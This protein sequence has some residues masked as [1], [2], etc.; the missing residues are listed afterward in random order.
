VQSDLRLVAE[1]QPAVVQ[2]GEAVVLRAV[3]TGPSDVTSAKVNAVIRDTGGQAIADTPL[4]DDGAHQDDGA[5]DGVFAATWTAQTASLYT[6]TLT[7][8]GQRTDGDAFQRVA[9]IAVQ[10]N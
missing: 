2:A 6:V 3:L 5:S 4:F 1:A 10:A 7:A 8:V 9:V